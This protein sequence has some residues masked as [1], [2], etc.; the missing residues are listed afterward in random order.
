MKPKTL[1][2][3]VADLERREDRLDD[4]RKTIIVGFVL[5]LLALAA[6]GTL[7]I[8]NTNRIDRFDRERAYRN[9]ARDMITRAELHAAYRQR[10]EVPAEVNQLAPNE[11]VL[12][13]LL[14]LSEKSRRVGLKRV[15]RNQPILDCSANLRGETPK[16]L[17]KK[18][19]DRFIGR[20]LRNELNPLPDVG[21]PARTPTSNRGSS[22]AGQLARLT[23]SPSRERPQARAVP[24]QPAEPHDQVTPP[25]PRPR[26]TPERP[27]A[28]GPPGPQGPQGPAG[29]TLPA[30]PTVPDAPGLIPQP[31]QP[32][33]CTLLPA[34]CNR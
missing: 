20:Y 34:L 21:A 32:V 27:P 26:T 1:T 9:C 7:A 5:A 18:A 31:L 24:Q 17:S 29:P 16:A 28:V 15:E 2:E 25:P 12:Q 4:F 23:P 10:I 14:L 8:R 11:P 22:S 30:A 19:Q 33:V 3:R 13:A 6:T